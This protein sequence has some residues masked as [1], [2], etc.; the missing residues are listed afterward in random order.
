MDEITKGQEE[1][2]RRREE[3]RREVERHNRGQVDPIPTPVK[4]FFQ[5]LPGELCESPS[6]DA[7]PKY[8]M[9]TH[10]PPP[11]ICDYCGAEVEPICADA[12]DPPRWG[13]GSCN[14]QQSRDHYAQVAREDAETK[15]SNEIQGLLDGAGLTN[16][17]AGRMSF[18]TWEADRNR[19]DSSLGV[20]KAL[21]YARKVQRDGRNWLFLHGPYGVGKTHL[22][23]AIL[24]ELVIRRRWRARMVVWP[25]HCAAV[26]ESWDGGNGPTE[27]QLWNRMRN[28]TVLLIDDLDKRQPSAWALGKLYEIIE[29][30]YSKERP[31]IITANRNLEQLSDMW[32][33]V[34]LGKSKGWQTQ[35]IRDAG[36]AIVSRVGGQLWG[37]IEMTGD[38]Q[39]W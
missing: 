16:G 36:G 13:P 30:R 1:L 3:H 33:N 18:E 9:A 15:R 12:F 17:R 8:P 29:M 5:G 14:C 35:Q 39:R 21:A 20:G 32:R 34:W 11:R 2:E 37:V 38:D 23:I 27:G 26:Q 19:P 6:P 22:A 25:E 24:R 28:A 10:K 4:S 7:T 31:T